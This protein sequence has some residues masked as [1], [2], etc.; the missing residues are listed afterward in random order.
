MKRRGG[1]AAHDLPGRAVG[2]FLSATAAFF[3]LLVL[4]LAAKNFDRLDG[5]SSLFGYR[6]STGEAV[7]LGETFA[8]PARLAD[9]IAAFFDDAV[10]FDARFFPPFF[11]YGAREFALFFGES[12]REFFTYAGTALLDFLSIGA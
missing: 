7:F 11:R 8:L 5:A 4:F 3:A 10:A 9:G 1:R 6:F 2:F 12:A